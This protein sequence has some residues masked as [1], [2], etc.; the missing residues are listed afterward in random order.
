MEYIHL[1]KEK[2][3][4]FCRIKQTVK[5]LNKK[6]ETFIMALGFKLK[7]VKTNG[8]YTIEDLYETIKNQNFTAG[9]PELSKHGLAKVITFPPLD[10]NNQVWIIPAFIGKSGNKFQVLKQQAVGVGNAVKNQILSDL[11]RGITG[12]SGVIGKKAREIEKLVEATAEELNAMG[13]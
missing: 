1:P 4:R 5:I 2:V 13:L 3:R 9:I 12:I 6:K 7:T 11:T 10:R 8:S